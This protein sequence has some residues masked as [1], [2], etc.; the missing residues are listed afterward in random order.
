[1]VEPGI[2]DY[3]FTSTRKMTNRR[4]LA[5]A[6]LALGAS[7]LLTSAAST[8]LYNLID[9]N[10]VVESIAQYSTAGAWNW[11]DYATVELTL[12]VPIP[13]NPSVPFTP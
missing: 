12:R 7:P 1:V 11:E 8:P 6:L 9:A 3:E 4:S 10:G 2:D 5:C 13:G